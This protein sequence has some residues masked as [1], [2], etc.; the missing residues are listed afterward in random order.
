MKGIASYSRISW[1][2]SKIMSRTVHLI[3]V[4]RINLSPKFENFNLITNKD[5]NHFCNH[6]NRFNPLHHPVNGKGNKHGEISPI[7]LIVIFGGNF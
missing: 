1:L 7:L 2:A 5:W 6:T 4:Y 3:P